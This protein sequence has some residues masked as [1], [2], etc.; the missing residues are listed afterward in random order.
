MLDALQLKR[1]LFV[2][3]FCFSL[4]LNADT[5]SSGN[6]DDF[7]TRGGG[8][9]Y[10]AYN[11]WLWPAQS[12][13]CL[14]YKGGRTFI[15]AGSEVQGVR[16]VDPA[17]GD[18]SVDEMDGEGIRFYLINER[19]T[20]F[21]QYHSRY[22]TFSNVNDFE[23]RMFTSTPLS[24]RLLAFSQLERQAIQQGVVVRGMSKEAV[25]A[26]FGWPDERFTEKLEENEWV[27]HVNRSTKI[28]IVFHHDLVHNRTQ[29]SH[30]DELGR[31][32]RAHLASYPESNLVN[33][34]PPTTSAPP[35]AS[36][37]QTGSNPGSI[38]P[39]GVEQKLQILKSLYEQ[40]L[41]DA[42]EYQR[43]QKEILNNM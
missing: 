32:G 19:R 22:H 12:M 9:M 35:A 18:D 38:Q 33:L 25:L 40:G 23:E 15:P 31:G 21:I 6:F 24:E 7:E 36:V 29:V 34:S 42:Q 30:I 3:F 13:N 39:L 37:P 14:N 8:V 26:C 17:S 41:I 27:Y 43:K 5:A 11:I 1:S 2:I 10:T 4:I 20:Y 28:K 16:V